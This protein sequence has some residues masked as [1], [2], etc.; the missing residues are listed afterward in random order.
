MVR[1]GDCVE[2]D[3]ESRKEED[4]SMNID[5]DGEENEIGSENDQP[6]EDEPDGDELVELSPNTMTPK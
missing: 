3:Q 2:E 4:Q 1:V 6:E 5:A